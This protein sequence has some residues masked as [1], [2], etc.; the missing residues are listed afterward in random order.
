MYTSRLFAI[1]LP[2]CILVLGCSTA[3]NVPKSETVTLVLS[4]GAKIRAQVLNISGDEVTFKARS[5]KKAY[6]YGEVL[7]KQRIVMVRLQDGAELSIDDFEA[8]DRQM[9]RSEKRGISQ[10]KQ[11]SRSVSK[12]ARNAIGKG[13]DAEY[14]QLKHK[15]ISDMTDREFEFFMMMKRQELSQTG[16]SKVTVASKPP[17]ANVGPAVPIMVAE[18]IVAAG[19]NVQR[20]TT[21]LKQVVA[22]L[23]QSKLARGYLVFL[24]EKDDSGERMSSTEA[25]LLSI[26]RQNK[27]I[28]DEIDE[29]AY[30]SDVAKK[31][32][33]YAHLHNP[34]ALSELGLEFDSEE[35]LSYMAIMKQLRGMF[36]ARMEVAEMRKL[37]TVIGDDGARAVKKLLED[38]DTY[39]FIYQHR[40]ILTAK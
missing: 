8:Y 35:E 10:N 23:I 39:E 7:P 2:F 32:L 25:L 40:S 11:K 27:T 38:F 5:V 16:Q 6:Q 15:S 18:P 30:I 29:L 26:L 4:D 12:K 28:K 19:T 31:K 36:G 24:T 22:S 20:S 17:I 34:E 1:M 14:E 33:E 9:A 3:R 37:V 13:P 21:E